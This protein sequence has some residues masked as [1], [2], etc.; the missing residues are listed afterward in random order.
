MNNLGLLIVDM[1][2]G[3]IP[4]LNKEDFVFNIKKSIE[5][6]NNKDLP[7]FFLESIEEG[8]VFKELTSLAKKI[9][10]VE[11]YNKNGFIKIKQEKSYYQINIEDDFPFQGNL[12][13]DLDKIL[14]SDKTESLLLA[15]VYKKDCVLNTA[16]GAKRRGFLIYSCDELM[17]RKNNIEPWYKKNSNKHF[18]K[19]NELIAFL[20]QNL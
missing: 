20:D 13:S 4:D 12:S 6:F 5:Y 8:Q 15:G 19:Y 11:K 2:P 16:K 9:R 17:D 10:I 7:I 1:Q 14:K 3:F 18:K